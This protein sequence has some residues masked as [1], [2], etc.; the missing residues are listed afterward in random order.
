MLSGMKAMT[1]PICRA[2]NLFFIYKKHYYVPF[3]FANEKIFY[4]ED[5]AKVN[6]ELNLFVLW[7]I[8]C[9]HGF[10]NHHVSTLTLASDV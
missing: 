2:R 8:P 1:G 4:A 3:Y 7:E 9:G 5:R 10:H 6:R